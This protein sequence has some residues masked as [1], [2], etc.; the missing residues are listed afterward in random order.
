MSR[1][2]TGSNIAVAYIGVTSSLGEFLDKR[3]KGQAPKFPDGVYRGWAHLI[4]DANRAF[5]YDED[6][7]SLPEGK[8]R[9]SQVSS[10][11]RQL[12][13][14]TYREVRG[15]SEEENLD[16]RAVIKEVADLTSKVFEAS[17]MIPEIKTSSEFLR[18]FFTGLMDKGLEDMETERYGN[19]GVYSYGTRDL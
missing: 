6:P 15:I 8:L 5:I 4:D 2:I 12:I 19:C 9:N 1:V 16:G 18:L 3:L 7:L 11:S 13:I 17:E 10:V 14:D